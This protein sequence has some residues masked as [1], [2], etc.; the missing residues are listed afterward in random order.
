MSGTLFHLHAS[1]VRVSDRSACCHRRYQEE[2]ELLDRRQTMY[3]AGQDLFGIP[4]TSFP[5]LDVTKKEMQLL[6]LLSRLYKDVSA[7]EADWSLCPWFSV[8]SRVD[9]MIKEVEAFTLRCKRMPASVSP[10]PPVS[11]SRRF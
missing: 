9:D 11:Q 5:E 4:R 2:L 1:A 6:D 8:P 3:K 7:M 10:P